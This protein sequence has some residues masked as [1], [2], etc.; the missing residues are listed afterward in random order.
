MNNRIL[1][2]INHELYGQFT[3]DQEVIDTKNKLI[4]DAEM[5]LNETAKAIIELSV[6]KITELEKCYADEIQAIRLAVP[7]VT[8]YPKNGILK[9]QLVTCE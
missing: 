5:M 1:A 4:S 8:S 3:S 9:I 2:T 7:Q 6:Q